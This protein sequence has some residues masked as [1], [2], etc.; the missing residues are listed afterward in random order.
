MLLV[1]RAYARLWAGQA[2]STVGDHVFDTTLVLWIGTVLLRGRSYAPVAVSGLLAV[3]ALVTML[4]APVAGVFVDRWD[5]RRT[6]LAAD[7]VRAGLVAALAAVAFLP[8]GTLP[9]TTLVALAYAVVAVTAAAAQFFNPARLALIGQVVADPADR[10]RAA[11]I[12]QATQS[13]AAIV[14]PPLAAP[15]LFTVGVRWSLLLDAVTFLV[16]FLAVR[17]VRVRAV[18]T[19]PAGVRRGLWP[20]FR[21]GLAFVG[22]SRVLRAVLVAVAVATLG[23]GALN[24]LNV[25]FVG[26]N[27]HAATRWYGTLDMAVGIGAVAGA[28]LAAAVAARLGNARVFAVGLLVVGLGIVA[29]ARVTALWPAL[30]LLVVVAVPLGEVNTVLGPILL[31]TVPAHLLG[32]VVSVLNPVQQVASLAGTALSGWLASTVLLGFHAA[33]LGVPFGRIDTVFVL[34]GL[35]I[36]A[37][38]G[39]ATVALRGT[40]R[41]AEVVD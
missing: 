30:V 34:A 26:T 40:D 4:V 36:V 24:T 27:L 15:L 1:N 19:D 38:G 3:V 8:A 29:Y 28:L 12:G 17:A 9:A 14:G 7:L 13:A 41:T 31:R 25:F 6:M 22:G 18:A 39:Y 37:G 32:R 2:V 21:A 11:G 16:S 20:E 10:S 5:R 35:L 23:T 33:P